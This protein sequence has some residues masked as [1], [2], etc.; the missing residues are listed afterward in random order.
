MLHAVCHLINSHVYG[1]AK[2]LPETLAASMNLL[3]E[4]IT[5]LDGLDYGILDP[6]TFG[7]LKSGTLLVVFSPGLQLIPPH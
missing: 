5:K 6:S 2:I 1:N 4:E 3:S 7:E